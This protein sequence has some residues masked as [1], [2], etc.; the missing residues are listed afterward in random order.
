MWMLWEI[1]KTIKE[2]NKVVIL[3]TTEVSVEKAAMYWIARSSGIPVTRMLRGE[4][5]PDELTT[6]GK[7]AYKV[8]GLPLFIIGYSSRRGKD[9]RRRK[10]KLTPRKIDEAIEYILNRYRDPVTN[11]Q[12]EVVAILTDY[13]Q[14]IHNDTQH[15]SVRFYT[16]CV[17]WAKDLAGWAGAPHI[18]NTQAKREVDERNIKIPMAADGQYTSNIEQTSDVQF[19][20][21]IP[22]KYN[23]QLM[24]EFPSWGIPELV[25]EPSYIYFVLLKQK[26]GPANKGWVLDAD[27]SRLTLRELDLHRFQ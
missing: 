9:G 14:R 15:N 10:P 7:H 6:V 22:H 2:P 19:S 26:D 23:I 8:M 25:V 1:I 18:L 11:S 16:E 13:L 21:H 24:P 12:I 27:L 20:V 4:L 17:N 3:I 5:T